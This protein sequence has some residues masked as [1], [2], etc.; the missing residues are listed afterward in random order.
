MSTNALDQTLSADLTKLLFCLF[1]QSIVKGAATFCQCDGDIE[2]STRL[3]VQIVWFLAV[4]DLVD[5]SLRQFRRLLSDALVRVDFVDCL[6]VTASGQDGG[7]TCLGGKVGD[8]A[9][10]CRNA[11]EVLCYRE[12]YI[13]QRREGTDHGIIR[14]LPHEPESCDDIRKEYA[15]RQSSATHLSPNISEAIL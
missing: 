7:F 13:E 11:E 8:L 5:L 10:R 4:L 6:E 9:N 14:S 12:W 15:R 2:C 1:I 3:F